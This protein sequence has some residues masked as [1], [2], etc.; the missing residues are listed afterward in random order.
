[1]NYQH[2]LLS[3]YR[4]SWRTRGP[5]AWVLALLLLAF[6][7]MT[8]FTDLLDP[9]ARA[10]GLDG[11]WRLYGA[12][13]CVAMA[14][15][16]VYFLRRHGS[17]R[18]QR[19]RTASV[20]FVQIAFAFSI[21]YAM[22]LFGQREYYFSYLWPL[23]IEY[24]YPTAIL[25]QP[26]P[27]ILYSF[28]GSLL[29]FPVLAFTFGK[30]FYCSWVCGC[31]GLAET[32][33][34]PFRHLSN[35]STRAWRFEQ[36]SIHAVLL[37][38][39]GTTAVVFLNWA[40]GQDHPAFSRIAFAVQEGYTFVVVTL[41]AGIFGVVLYPLLGSRVW[42]RFFCPMA[43]LLGLVQKFGRFRIAVKPNMCISCG[44]CSA[45]CEMGIDVRAY[46]QSNQSFQRAACV[47]CGICAHVC[48]RGVLRL[49]SRWDLSREKVRQGLRVL[50]L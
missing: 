26:V 42:C 4:E 10:I 44:N 27:I 48:P 18:Y 25:Q 15:G 13:Y 37:A 49:E 36:I 45:Y 33:G 16:A 50:D 8:Y 32:A 31:G 17:S 29:L 30:R 11:K 28:L 22:I 21:P 24:F 41:L 23:K 38:A 46:A 34:D 43:A 1:M 9:V 19:I 47:G 7:L 12:L 35:K 5:L 40:I 3:T 6:Y 20:L 2:G 39:L 14:G